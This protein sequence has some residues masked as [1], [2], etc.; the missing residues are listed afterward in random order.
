MKQNTIFVIVDSER[1]INIIRSEKK[2]LH[3]QFGVEEIALF[4]S[5]ARNEAEKNSDVDLLVKMK[6]PSYN[7]LV[8]LYDYLEKKLLLKVDVVRK[9]P[10]LT[11]RFLNYIDKDLI[12]A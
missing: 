12:Y 5:Y 9:G 7:L 8:G 6:R 11:A 4:G 1:I 2:F 10:H 3:D